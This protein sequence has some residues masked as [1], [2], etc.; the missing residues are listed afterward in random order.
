MDYIKGTDL[1]FDKPGL[2]TERVTV[3]GRDVV[4]WGYEVSQ[5]GTCQAMTSFTFQ[6]RGWKLEEIIMYIDKQCYLVFPNPIINNR[7]MALY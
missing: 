4:V 3:L 1:L 5:R 6:K 2:N 7:V